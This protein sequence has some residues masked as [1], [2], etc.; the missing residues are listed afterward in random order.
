MVGAHQNTHHP[1]SIHSSIQYGKRSVWESF[2]D[3]WNTSKTRNSCF[4]FW[5]CPHRKN[6]ELQP[7]HRRREPRALR[8]HRGAWE[9]WVSRSPSAERGGERCEFVAEGTRRFP[10]Q[11]WHDS[12]STVTGTQK[13]V[14][15]RSFQMIFEHQQVSAISCSD[16]GGAKTNPLP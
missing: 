16:Q 10:D 7:F 3:I 14:A 2:K 5:D 1:A 15:Q 4:S 13:R 8:L 12:L 6:F 11:S 9:G